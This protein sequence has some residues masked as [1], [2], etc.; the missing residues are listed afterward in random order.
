[1]YSMTGYGKAEY[2][3]EEVLL[4]M[5]LR[6]I[7]N[8]NLDINSKVPRAFAALEDVIRKTIGEY[9]GR[10]RIDVFVTFTDR[11]EKT[12]ALEIDRGLAKSYLAAAQSLSAEFSLENDITV[13]QLMRNAEIVSFSG[14][15]PDLEFLRDAVRE[16]TKSACEELNQMRLA[17]GE[18]LKQDIS[19]RMGTIRGI[20][21]SIKA[22]A[23]EVASEFRARLSERMKEI[24][25]DV[26][27]DES[28]L[29]NEVAFFADKS[30]I[31]EELTRLSSHITQFYKII[32]LPA[33]GKKLDFLIQEFN[34]EA[35]TICSKANDLAV[36]NFGLN[37]K[38]EIE[39]IRE[40]IQNIE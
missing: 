34:R 28:R 1:M 33:A 31:D 9:V 30:N 12:A 18:K 3:T 13:S 6:S 36:T 5:E 22:R 29:L 17:E 14:E 25:A 23:P 32:D 16:V 8:R 7:N 26:E 27:P 38:C 35:N 4:T 15:T 24:L 20:V 37:L 11:R 10:G 2:R 19:V 21:D 39:K 40:Q